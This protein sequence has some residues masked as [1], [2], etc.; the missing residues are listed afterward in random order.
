MMGISAL[1]HFWTWRSKN[2]QKKVRI[3]E[4]NLI[5]VHIGRGGEVSFCTWHSEV[6]AVAMNSP[7]W[8]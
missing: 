5:L 7:A 1:I 6:L 2:N 8:V 4:S 3:L